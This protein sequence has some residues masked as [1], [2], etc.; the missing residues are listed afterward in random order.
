MSRLM[1]AQGVTRHDRANAA[2][3]IKIIK[4]SNE[5]GYNK[6]HTQLWD[7]YIIVDWIL[8]I[9]YCALF[10]PQ[11]QRAGKSIDLLRYDITFY[12]QQEIKIIFCFITQC[13]IIS[14]PFGD[15]TIR[16]IKQALKCRA[17]SGNTVPG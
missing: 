12:T 1:S 14:L 17:G 8:L 11:H 16:G 4:F 10:F 13:F 2:K 5:D 9:A 3:R 6:A 7:K 15:D